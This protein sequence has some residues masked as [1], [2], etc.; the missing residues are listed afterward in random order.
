M[1]RAKRAVPVVPDG[2]QRRAGRAC[3]AE[4]VDEAPGVGKVAAGA[5]GED[6]L[7]LLTV[8][9]IDDDLHGHARIERR[10]RRGRRAATRLIAAGDAA[11]PLRPMNSVR[12]PVMVRCVSLA[13]E[14]SDAV[15]ELVVVRVAGEQRS[16]LGIDLGDDVREVRRRVACPGRAR[17]IPSPTGGAICRNCCAA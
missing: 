4:T 14:E 8:R 9:Q 17:K 15:A 7:A 12:S 3:A 2:F 1:D 10:R 13:V 11:V 6:D 16:G 5:E